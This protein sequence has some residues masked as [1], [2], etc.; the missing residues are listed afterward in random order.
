LS[1][2]GSTKVPANADRAAG[3]AAKNK[4]GSYLQAQFLRL[5]ICRRTQTARRLS[6]K[7]DS[8]APE[9]VRRRTAR[10]FVLGRRGPQKAVCAVATSI[11]TAAYHMLKDGTLYSDLGADHFNRRS[12]TTQAQ[13]FVNRLKHLG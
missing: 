9:A 7:A 3:W 1:A 11:L 12:K 5:R 10:G 6:G 2:S 8:P 13:R 4:K